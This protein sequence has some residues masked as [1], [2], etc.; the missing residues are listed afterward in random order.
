MSII[1]TTKL[2][3]GAMVALSFCSVDVEACTGIRLK[4]QDGSVVYG[5]SME[6]GAFDLHSRVT[7]I[8]R[9]MMHNIDIP[10]HGKAMSWKG[11]YGYVGLDYVGKKSLIDGINEKGLAVGGFYHPGGYC[12]YATFDK[13]TAS[14]SMTIKE[15]L[16]YILSVAEDIEEAKK[17]INDVLVVDFKDDKF[18]EIGM[19]LMVTDAKGESIV[20]EWKDGK[21][22]IFDA[23]LGVITNAPGYDWHII[24][25]NNYLGLSQKAHTPKTLSG[26]NFKPLGAGSGFIGLPGD[27]TPPSRFIRA[28]AFTQ[29]ARKTPNSKETMYEL[30]R[31]LDNFNL[32]L[33]SAEGSE[34]ST[35]NDDLMRSS[36]IWTTGYD[37]TNRVMFYHTQ[38]NRRLRKI[39]LKKID[40][41]HM[42]KKVIFLKL[43]EKKEQDIEDRTPL[44]LTNK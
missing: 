37:L 13:K 9:G 20:V 1:K 34:I 11:K 2:A 29:T 35:G 23:P 31:I 44:D 15:F 26:I 4:A 22:K 42:G 40:F 33:G 12:K 25:L 27:V 32:G 28:V 24:N 14:K 6:W 8:P 5:R 18:P 43:D 41:G 21:V 30:F 7:I 10:G 38:H 16:P 39:D 3:L 36:T 19:H 17:A